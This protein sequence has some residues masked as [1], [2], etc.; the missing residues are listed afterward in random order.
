MTDQSQGGIYSGAS[1]AEIA[2]DLLELVN[3]QEQGLP[4]ETLTRLVQERLVPHLVRYDLPE[5]HSLYNFLPE[6]GALLGG[7]VA[8][9]YNQGVTNW[10][11][12]PGGV[13]LEEMCVQALCQLFGFPPESDAT[14]M[15]CG[16]YA[17]QQALYMALHRFAELQGFDLAEKGIQGFKDPER[18]AIVVS[19]DVHFSLKHAVRI[20][21]LGDLVDVL[22]EA[23]HAVLAEGPV[24]RIA[25][26]CCLPRHHR[27]T[28]IGRLAERKPV[29]EQRHPVRLEPFCCPGTDPVV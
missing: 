21:G 10:Q 18:P 24:K 12:S 28:R 13:M 17:N 5:F 16:T 25:H 7:A 2:V 9:R 23:S 1:P 6:K 29:K 22:G 15:Y 20:L 11:V 4:M 3:F 14:F 26:H 27:L 19:Q 8:L